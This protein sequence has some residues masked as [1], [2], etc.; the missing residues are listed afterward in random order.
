MLSAGISVSTQIIAQNMTNA[1]SI[2]DTMTPSNINTQMQSVGI[3][4]VAVS[5]SASIAVVYELKKAPEALVVADNDKA[6]TPSG[7]AKNTH[8]PPSWVY[9]A[10]LCTACMF[11]I[12]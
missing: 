8:R 12:K 6:W 2:A 4:E 10:V 7:G 9:A 5:T 11:A 1:N 3:P